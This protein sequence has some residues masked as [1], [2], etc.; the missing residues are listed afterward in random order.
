MKAYFSKIV[1]IGYAPG[2][3]RVPTVTIKGA[4]G[5]PLVINESDYDS[6]THKLWEG[7]VPEPAQAPAPAPAPTPASAPDAA[8]LPGA[9]Q[10]LVLK[11]GSGKATK[12]Y[13]SDGLGQRITGDAAVELGIDENGYATEAEAKTVQSN[14][15]KA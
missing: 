2:F 8:K 9:D 13:I 15:K 7:D 4:D 10:F 1:A 5:Q 3:G 11:S 14:L 12:F 6:K